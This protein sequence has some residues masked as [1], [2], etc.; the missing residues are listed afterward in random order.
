MNRSNSNEQGMAMEN[1]LYK[2]GQLSDVFQIFIASA[3]SNPKPYFAAMDDTLSYP[4]IDPTNFDLIIV[5]TGLPE[6]ILAAAASAAGKTVLHL[7][8]NSFYG[9]HFSSLPLSD[10]TSFL[11]SQ[12]SHH[13]PPPSS[14][15]SSCSADHIAIDLSS[16]PMY[17]DLDI[18]SHSPEPLQHS[19]TFN[20]DLAGPRVFFCADSAVDLMLKSGASHYM[21]FKSVDANFVCDGDGKLLSV[22]DSR[23][24]IFSDTSLGLAEKTRRISDEDLESPFVDFL[25]KLRLPPKIN[26]TILYAIAMA[27]YD[28]DSME[29]CKDFLKTKDGINRLALYHSS[30][31]SLGAECAFEYEVS[32]FVEIMRKVRFSNALGPLIYP[33]YG[34][35]ELPQ[36]FCRH[37]AVKGCLYVLRMPVN[38][39]LMDKDSGSYKGVKV[40]SGQELFSHRIVLGPSFIVPSPLLKSSPDILQAKLKDFGLQDFRG[41]VARGICITKSSLKPDVSTFLAVYPPKSLYP[42]QVAS[43]RVLQIGSSLAVCPSG[44]YVLYL[45]TLCGDAIQGKK[46]LHAAVNAIFSVPISGTPENSNTDESENADVKPTL[47]WSALYIQEMATVCSFGSIF[48]TPM[49]D[50]NLNYNDLLDATKKLFYMMFP[51]EEFFPETVRLFSIA[52]GPLIY[53]IYGQGELPQAFCRHAVV[54]GSSAVK[55]LSWD[56]RLKIAV[57]AARGLAFLHTSDKKVIYRDFKASNILLDGN[58]KISD[59]DLAKLGPSGEELH[60]TTQVM[61]LQNT[62]QQIEGQYSSKAAS[63]AVNSLYSAWNQNLENFPP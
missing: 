30:V 53:P 56:I 49:P 52:L 15:S 48:S 58:A 54:K 10:L 23:S 35:G 43:I 22:P 12:S 55:P 7:D 51:D 28:Q 31:G 40:G 47:L 36:A 34:Q 41:K 29:V 5:G 19:R 13:S 37:A 63:I 42:E 32:H 39:L 20:L 61:L 24:A 25:N 2:P 14:S 1:L 59:F 16:S 8:P 21:E 45:S 18:S 27:D 3:I 44:I 9:S 57:G 38:A 33:I 11:H 17:S 60:V 26:S 4:P 50:G 46:S 6:S 62:L